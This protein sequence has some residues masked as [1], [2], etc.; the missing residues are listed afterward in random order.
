MPARL[1]SSGMS[2]P[3][4]SSPLKLH[5][6]GALLF[7]LTALAILGLNRGARLLAEGRTRS[8]VPAD[9]A[10]RATGP[11][12][13]RGEGDRGGRWIVM[14]TAR[15]QAEFAQPE[16]FA[17]ELVAS[18][19]GA[20]WL[21]FKQDE[22]DELQSGLLFYPSLTGSVAPGFEHDPLRPLLRAL[23]RHGIRVGAWVPALHDASAAIRHPSWR[24]EDVFDDGTRWPQDSWL[25]P[26][27]PGVIAYQSSILSEIA[28]GYPE[29]D[30]IYTDFIRFDSDHS[31]VCDRC[32]GQ[33]GARRGEALSPADIRAAGHQRTDLWRDWVALR[34][35]LV[36]EMIS[37]MRS[38]IDES[39]ADMWF[40]AAVLPFSAK[41]YAFNTQ[42]GQDL[43]EMSRAGLD[44]I[45]LMGYWD[46]W[47][48]K[49]PEW[50]ADSIRAA[51]A[52][53]TPECSLSVLLDADM[54]RRRMVRTLRATGDD[55][56]DRGWFEYGT[57]RREAIALIDQAEAIEESGASTDVTGV[58]DVV[59]RIDTEPDFQRRYDTTDP[60]M[61]D[62]IC[63]LLESFGAR[64]T[65]VT[66]ARLAELQADAVRDAHARGHEIA[67]HAYDHEQ[68]D[69]L[70]PEEQIAIMDK[71]WASFERLGIPVTGF[72]APRN[73]ATNTTRRWLLDRAAPWDGSAAWD[74]A[75]WFDDPRTWP[76]PRDP[77]G[78]LV[79]PFIMPNDWDARHVA[80]MT[81]EEMCRA[82]IDRLEIVRTMGEP[83]FVIDV[84]QWLIT[85]P[86]N[87]AALGAFLTNVSARRDCRLSTLTEAAERYRTL[88]IH[89]GTTGSR[90]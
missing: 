62:Q 1:P 29:L 42:A 75:A 2:L 85:E 56:V 17:K 84:H 80:G 21:Q 78:L 54:S 60:A 4:P 51:D 58:T 5:L 63:D 3:D 61:I 90:E 22:N 7:A 19:V 39:R 23:T 34:A 57:W 16:R 59:I 24:A 38:A 77:A 27:E 25:C 67:V 32:L 40:G 72:G 83:V 89:S 47:H 35:E 49:S 43:Y 81:A 44:E 9:P 74:P 82:W 18:G 6:K 37:S 41:D 86:D 30:A 14:R 69:D 50:L 53:L 12:T 88:L 66:C 55:D 31:C 20:V 10:P 15:H 64:G 79:I 26:A 28:V 65:F 36:C 48:G 73:S 45:V 87:L 71:S 33:L 68:L 76:E 52:L 13:E 46:D 11:L 8:P 70:S